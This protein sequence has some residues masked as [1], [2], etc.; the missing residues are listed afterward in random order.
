MSLYFI[1]AFFD[2]NLEKDLSYDWSDAIHENIICDNEINAARDFVSQEFPEIEFDQN[3][4]VNKRFIYIFEL[5]KEKYGV[6]NIIRSS[7]QLMEYPLPREFILP[8]HNRNV[9][10][11]TNAMMIMGRVRER[12]PNTNFELLYDFIMKC[13]E[14]GRVPSLI[15]CYVLLVLNGYVYEGNEVDMC[16]ILNMSWKFDL[17]QNH[18]LPG[19]CSICCEDRQL[20]QIPCVHAHVDSNICKNCF[21]RLDT[22]PF[23]RSEF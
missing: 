5:L 9:G 10:V 3:M 1:E 6:D 21:V 4:Y 16:N 13:I 15:D 2:N 8:N 18:E 14:E 7:Y 12:H 11:Y 17:C 20:K 23:C 22:C 19:E